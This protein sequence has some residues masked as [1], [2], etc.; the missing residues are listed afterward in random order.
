MPK[1]FS[2]RGFL[3]PSFLNHE[4]LYIPF[5]IPKAF[6]AF[7]EEELAFYQAPFSVIWIGKDFKG[8]AKAGIRKWKRKEYSKSSMISAKSRCIFWS[9]V[10]MVKNWFR[11]KKKSKMSASKPIVLLPHI[12][13]WL[14]TPPRM[15]YWY[16]ALIWCKD[17]KSGHWRYQEYCPTQVWLTKFFFLFRIKREFVTI[18]F[19][20]W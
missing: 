4:H 10:A 12:S 20:K 16:L 7:L 1:R 8:N 17:S 2:F 5:R 13:F 14:M 18:S 19:Q 11:L 3:A 9:W 6:Y 15:S